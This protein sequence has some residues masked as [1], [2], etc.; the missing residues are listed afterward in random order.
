MTSER[1]HRLYSPSQAAAF[2]RCKGRQRAT[3]RVPREPDSVYAIEGTRA[4]EV[5]QAALENGFVDAKTAHREYSSLFMY[6]LDENFNEFYRSINDAIEYVRFVLDS[7]PDAKMWVE[8]FVNPPIESAPGEAGGYC[9]IGIYLPAT[10]HLYVIDYKHGA[11]VGVT[12]EFNKQMMQYGA[13]FLYD[14]NSPLDG[15]E[16]DAVTLVI[17]QP[18]NFMRPLSEWE[19]TPFTLYEYLQEL[20]AVVAECE[21][22]DAPLTPDQIACRW[23]DARFTC[24]ARTAQALSVANSTWSTIADVRTD[25]LPAPASLEMRQLGAILFHAP[26]LRKWLDDMEAHAY[27]LSQTGH[28]VPG[29]KLVETAERREYYEDEDATVANILRLLGPDADPTQIFQTKLAPLT[30]V[31]KLVVDAY[32][33]RVPRGKKK[34]AAE[35]ARR[36]FALLTLKKSSGKLTLVRE[37]DPRPAVRRDNFAQLPQ[38]APPPGLPSP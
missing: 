14:E 19:T 4:H 5:L 3:L 1:E 12:A 20:D 30:Y 36:A 26:T 17:V 28:V 9:D 22:P 38:I 24:P 7:D 11:G 15:A 37:D 29:F 34:Q 21:A 31:E 10:K 16:V 13:G 25:L 18:R 8:A 2:F 6:D 35:E 33:S 27:V 32:K 23:C